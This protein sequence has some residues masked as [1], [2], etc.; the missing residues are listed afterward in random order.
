MR[1]AL[2][3]S[4]PPNAGSSIFSAFYNGFVDISIVIVYNNLYKFS[5]I[6]VE[7]IDSQLSIILIL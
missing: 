1:Q 2:S 7:N 4:C 5:K 3:G 6:I